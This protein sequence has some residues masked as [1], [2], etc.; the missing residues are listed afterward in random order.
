MPS[1][2]NNAAAYLM[3]KSGASKGSI[4]KQLASD[5]GTQGAKKRVSMKDI[6]KAVGV[7][8]KK[9][10]LASRVGAAMNRRIMSATG[11]DKVTS[12]LKER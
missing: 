6:D 2:D 8:K 7:K 3:S 4:R 11:A 12:A 10:S 5:S 9:R 1:K